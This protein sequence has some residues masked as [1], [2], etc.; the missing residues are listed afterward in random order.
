MDSIR[1]WYYTILCYI[2][3]KDKEPLSWSNL[4]QKMSAKNSM[5]ERLTSLTGI[6]TLENLYLNS[7]GG[8]LKQVI[9]MTENGLL[10]STVRLKR[11]QIYYQDSFKICRNRISPLKCL[12]DSLKS[13]N[14]QTSHKKVRNIGLLV[15]MEDELRCLSSKNVVLF[16]KAAAFCDYGESRIKPTRL[17]VNTKHFLD[18]NLKKVQKTLKKYKRRKF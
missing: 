18:E 11:N 12:I 3:W 6:P 9:F 14:I 8:H 13:K 2:T 7:A 10:G 1:Y 16:Q 4:H 15:Q 17:S 5:I